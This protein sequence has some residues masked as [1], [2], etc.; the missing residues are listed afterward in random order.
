[1]VSYLLCLGE[2]ELRGI[3]TCDCQY[4]EVEE[5]GRRAVEDILMV[6]ATRITLPYK[7]VGKAP[8]RLYF[9]SLLGTFLVRIDTSIAGRLGDGASRTDSCC[10]DCGQEVEQST[11][12]QDVHL[13]RRRFSSHGLT[14]PQLAMGN[15]CENLFLMPCVGS[16]GSCITSVYSENYDPNLENTKE[17]IE[18]AT[19]V[20]LDQR[21]AFNL[22]YEGHEVLLFG[23]YPQLER[24]LLAVYKRNGTEAETGLI[25][26]FPTLTFPNH[27]SI[28]TGLYP[29]Y[30]GI[31]AN[32]FTDPNS[33]ETFTKRS[34]EPHW[35]LGEPLWQTVVKDG[36]IA[37]T[38]F[39]P[40]SEVKKG[41]WNCPP[42][43]CQPFNKKV[44]FE[45]RVDTVLGYF[46]LPSDEIP[47]FMTVYFQ[48]P[49]SQGHRVGPDH[50]EITEAVANIDR[51]IGKLITG[52]EKRGVFDDVN[53]IMVGDHG[54]VGTCDGK[55][56]Y[57]EDLAPWIEIPESWVQSYYPLLA[58]R[59]PAAVSPALV[60]KNM[61]EGLNSSTVRNGKN[62]KM[63]LKE[64]FPAR[65]HY[66]ANYRISPIIGL[67]DEGFMVEQRNLSQRTCAGAHGYD[68][69]YFSMRTI[70]IGH[71][72]K[73]AKGR[74]VPSFENVQIY[75]MVTSILNI[76]G[77]SNNG[78]DSFANFV[79][80]PNR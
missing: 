27:Y 66:S 32:W 74:K 75:N 51:I 43:Y 25:P 46:D 22:C 62:L 17:R 13:W 63:F 31:I 68:N 24:Q 50:P 76:Q 10:V 67:L 23:I 58:I 70:F 21:R 3:F 5:F 53:I 37:A 4:W 55:S 8:I 39:W 48:D 44:P 77:A 7:T 59:P 35:W 38:Y 45:E 54:M 6:N 47:S 1:M 57:L 80:L 79:L 2:M 29:A 42:K 78:T 56:L 34:Q 60:V 28:V 12:L 33:G 18:A 52:L 40:G 65:L 11:F 19:V 20:Q 73:F 71:G 9:F 30:H 69:A 36:L 64:D 14:P 26:V 72:P 16:F 15:W 49:D 41:S 61:T